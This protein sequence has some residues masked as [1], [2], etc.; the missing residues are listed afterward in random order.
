MMTVPAGER[1]TPTA[2]I[3]STSHNAAQMRTTVVIMAPRTSSWQLEPHAAAAAVAHRVLRD[4]L[5]AGRLER[6]H[7]LHQGIDIAADHAA[8]R[9]HALDGRERETGQAGKRA[10]IDAE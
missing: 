8:A 6:R 2:R 5:D 3:A 1:P 4:E 9:L 10:L 7:E